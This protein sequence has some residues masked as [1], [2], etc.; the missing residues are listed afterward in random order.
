MAP[1]SNRTMQRSVSE[2][3]KLH[4]TLTFNQEFPTVEERLIDQ[5]SDKRLKQQELKSKK[6]LLPLEI[7]ALP[8]AERNEVLRERE[9]AA[10]KEKQV[11]PRRAVKQASLR[12]AKK[13]GEQAAQAY[14]A[15]ELKKLDDEA[16]AKQAE[17]ERKY[18]S[19]GSTVA[20]AD[21]VAA[22][23]QALKEETAKMQVL[24]QQLSEK[25]RKRLKA[26][27]TKL[28]RQNTKLQARFDTLS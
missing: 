8:E 9:L 16:A 20:P 3:D 27:T 17:L 28:T 19:G 11:L 25:K 10:F 1:K 15:A 2:R 24:Q 22:Y 6:R 18:P 12:K 13:E 26:I 7:A 4:S 23:N 14:Q 21:A 5:K